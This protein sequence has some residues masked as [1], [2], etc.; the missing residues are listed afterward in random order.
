[1]FSD[2]AMDYSYDDWLVVTILTHG[3]QFELAAEDCLYPRYLLPYFF[4]NDKCPTLAG[5]PKVFIIQ[6]CRR[7]RSRK[8]VEIENL[9]AIPD[10][11]WLE[12]ASEGKITS[13]TNTFMKLHYYF[14]TYCN[15]T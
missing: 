5:K 12:A 9:P 13:D 4:A 11:L 1:M 10:I 7:G 14:V 2:A 8:K 3:N 15:S 6:A